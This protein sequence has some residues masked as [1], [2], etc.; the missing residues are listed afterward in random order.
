M[1]CWS[2]SRIL[3]SSSVLVVL[4]LKTNSRCCCLVLAPD[5]WW[6]CF[7]TEVTIYSTCHV[8]SMP[9]NKYLFF[10]PFITN[11]NLWNLLNTTECI[12][13]MRLRLYFYQGRFS[14]K[15]PWMMNMLSTVK[16][17]WCSVVLLGCF[18]SQR[19]HQLSSPQNVQLPLLHPNKSRND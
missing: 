11:D 18:S 12:G 4:F 17:G 10:L 1:E 8:R 15:H 16:Y 6:G 13:Q 2:W 3:F 14:L 19:L 7:L 9:A 5:L